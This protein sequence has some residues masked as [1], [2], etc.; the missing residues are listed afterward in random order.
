MFVSEEKA[1]VFLN[2]L[3]EY[4][5]STT[6]LLRGKLELSKDIFELHSDLKGK[7]VCRDD[8]VFDDNDSPSN[9]VDDVRSPT[10]IP[11]TFDPLQ[12]MRLLENIYQIPPGDTLYKC[13]IAPQALYPEYVNDKDNIIL[14][15]HLFHIYFDG[16]GKRRPAGAN[17]DWGIPPSF[18][19]E[20][21]STGDAHKYLGTRYFRINVLITFDDPHKARAMEGHWREGTQ[22]VVTCSFAVIS[23]PRMR[24]I[25]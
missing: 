18:K 23:T 21:E 2:C 8:Y 4:N 17:L 9:T 16:D 11:I 5:V 19:L 22:A 20:Y 10:E 1:F 6:S 13:H 3:I 14:G 24:R 7:F 15:S 12:E 25:V